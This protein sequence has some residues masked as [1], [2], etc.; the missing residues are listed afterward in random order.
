MDVPGEVMVIICE[1]THVVIRKRGWTG[2]LMQ[3]RL[4]TD[5]DRGEM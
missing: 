5:G 2:L 1:V 4:W 3:S